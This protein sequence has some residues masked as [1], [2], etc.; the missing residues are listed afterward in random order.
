MV[1]VTIF[2]II[3]IKILFYVNRYIKKKK[4]N[5]SFFF[6]F[7]LEIQITQTHKNNGIVNWGKN[8]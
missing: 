7:F 1:G 8:L 2:I 5:A 6:F 3:Y 4:K